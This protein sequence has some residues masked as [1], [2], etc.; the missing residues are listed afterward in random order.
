[1]AERIPIIVNPAA[2]SRRASR[3]IDQLRALRPEPELFITEYA[4]HATEIAARLAGEGRELV[5][6]AE[7]TAR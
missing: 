6:A 4:G 3:V 2:R 5:V 1:M 7:G